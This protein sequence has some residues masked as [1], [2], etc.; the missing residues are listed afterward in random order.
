MH[1]GR[2]ILSF[3]AMPNIKLNFGGLIGAVG[4]LAAAVAIVYI[5]A[6]GNIPLRTAK[7]AILAAIGGGLL[8]NFLWGT[9]FPA[10]K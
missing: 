3:E 4:C 8:G 1:Q 7:V 5:L 9:F 10:G 6:G 2:P